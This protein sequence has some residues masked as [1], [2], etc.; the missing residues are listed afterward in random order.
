[1]MNTG[2][3]ISKY[4]NKESKKDE[5]EPGS[6]GPVKGHSATAVYPHRKVFFVPSG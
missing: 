2:G 1:M 4:Q 6:T 3:R 5:G